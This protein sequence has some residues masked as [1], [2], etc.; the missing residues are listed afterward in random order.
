MF[1]NLLQG[2][3]EDWNNP[4]LER[5]E[6]YHFLNSWTSLKNHFLETF[7]VVDRQSS[8]SKEIQTLKQT[9]SAV[10]YVTKFQQLAADLQGWSEITLIDIFRNGLKGEI[11]TQMAGTNFASFAEITIRSIEIDNVLRN[12]VPRSPQPQGQA[13]DI[14]A[15]AIAAAAAAPRGGPKGP[16]TVEERARRIANGLCLYCG[17]AHLIAACPICPGFRQG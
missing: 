10:T 9:T 4:H 13:M 17:G 7:S 16:I 2:A 11:Q 12:I 8:A 15:V 3:A 6:L 5:P 1:N 14:D